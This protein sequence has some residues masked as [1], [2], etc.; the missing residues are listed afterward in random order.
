VTRSGATS[1]WSALALCAALALGSAGAARAAPAADALPAQKTAVLFGQK[2]RYY[3]MGRGPTVV[4]VHGLGSSARG[5]WGKVMRSLSVGHRV[6]ALD[7]LGFGASDKPVIAYGI[8]TWVDFLGE[9]LRDR[10]VGEFT[11]VGE[12]L[13]GWISAQYTIQALAGQAVGPEFL[14]PKPSK[15]V[16][17]DAAGFDRAAV[18][19]MLD[20]GSSRLPTGISLAGQKRLLAAVFHDPA[21]SSDKGLR[22]GMAWAI[23]KGDGWTIQSFMSN[24]TIVDEAGGEKL[25][26]ITIPTL[27]VWGQY[28]ELVPLADGQGYAAAIRG[29]KLVVIPD[30]GHAPMIEAPAL[31]LKAVEDF[32]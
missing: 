29:A 23:S 18:G 4:L 5:D 17:S 3:E 26:G 16:L 10:K 14:L 13:G 30:V 32:L 27:V 6:L 31:F 2:I 28:D 21:Y 11:L 24:R 15:L 1:R 12:S 7:L 22:S 8:Q 19:S 20:H 9:F 25:A